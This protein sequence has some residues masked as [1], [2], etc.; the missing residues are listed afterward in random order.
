MEGGALWGPSQRKGIS[1]L[2]RERRGLIDLKQ[3]PFTGSGM[4][5]IQSPTR[6][7]TLNRETT[8]SLNSKSLHF[9]CWKVCYIE[10]VIEAH[11]AERE[12]PNNTYEKKRSRVCHQGDTSGKK[13]PKFRSKRVLRLS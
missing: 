6:G 12:T 1:H 9:L 10:G 11:Y 2:L 5:P 8:E 7:A 13:N 3:A 4:V